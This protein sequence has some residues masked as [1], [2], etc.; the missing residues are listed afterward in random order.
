MRNPLNAF[1]LSVWVI[2]VLIVAFIA[3]QYVATQTKRA[4]DRVCVAPIM[5]A[6]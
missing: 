4:Q 2:I 1:I 3:G 6:R 5:W